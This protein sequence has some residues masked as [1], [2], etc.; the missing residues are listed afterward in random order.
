MK[1]QPVVEKRRG[2]RPKSEQASCRIEFEKYVITGFYGEFN[3]WQKGGSYVVKK[4][5]QVWVPTQEMVS[6]P[7][8]YLTSLANVLEY[9]YNCLWAELKPEETK[10]QVETLKELLVVAKT[11]DSKMAAIKKQ[12]E[13]ATG[14]WEFVMSKKPAKHMKGK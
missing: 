2:R 14:K 8:V 13:L 10:G 3:V 11:I 5:E 7:T 12:A 1:S 9:V 4:G 6:V